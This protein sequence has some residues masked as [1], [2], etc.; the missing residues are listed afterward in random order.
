MKRRSSSTLISGGEGG[1]NRSQGLQD[2]NASREIMAA[3][4]T[5]IEAGIATRSEG[6]RL[7]T[8]NRMLP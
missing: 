4:L 1:K 3:H 7:A 2:A 6:N 8:A 5:E